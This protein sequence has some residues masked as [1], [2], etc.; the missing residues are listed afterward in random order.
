[1]EGK[2]MV[3]FIR[4]LNVRL[5]EAKK[6]RCIDYVIIN[7]CAGEV[8]ETF[9]GKEYAIPIDVEKISNSIGIEMIKQPLENGCLSK[10]MQKR[11]I[12]N[13]E[14]VSVL[15]VEEDEI[16]EKQ[17]MAI[18]YQ[19]AIYILRYKEEKYDKEYT[20]PVLYYKDEEEE[21]AE[22]FAR[23]LILPLQIVQEEF[24]FML[25]TKKNKKID[26]EKWYKYL[27]IKAM[28]PYEE[29]VLGWQQIKILT[30]K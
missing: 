6:G 19:I 16:F 4:S 25:K 5:R 14:K 1:M 29:A 7:Q 18:A 30:L 10:M 20:G 27:G 17:R 23:A 13:S 2:L 26:N 28:I 22:I 3:E 24:E 12:T 11:K 15:F 8:L 9:L 21:I